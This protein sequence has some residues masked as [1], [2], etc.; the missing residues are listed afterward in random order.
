M[1]RVTPTVLFYDTL[2]AL[3]EGLGTAKKIGKH[4]GYGP[5]AAYKRIKR[6]RKF[7]IEIKV[8]MDRSSEEEAGNEAAYYS[9]TERLEHARKK[10]DKGLGMRPYPT[11]SELENNVA[12]EFLKF[13]IGAY[14][15]RDEE[16]VADFLA[17][18]ELREQRL[19]VFLPYAVEVKIDLDLRDIKEQHLRDCQ[20]GKTMDAYFNGSHF[21]LLK[22]SYT[23]LP[24]WYVGRDDSFW[25]GQIGMKRAKKAVRWVVND[26]LPYDFFEVGKRELFRD[27]EKLGLAD[28][29]SSEHLPFDGDPYRAIYLAMR[30]NFPIENF[31]LYLT[32]HLRARRAF[33]RDSKESS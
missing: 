25:E 12:I 20:F 23:W 5:D 4:L 6:L 10:I 1:G 18:E 11:P 30:D 28:M 7:G 24:E 17:D 33:K 13:Y 22:V 32:K 9:L 27:F 14:D 2:N 31:P 8:L 3:A 21:E 26:E 19:R 15:R 16:V 29:L